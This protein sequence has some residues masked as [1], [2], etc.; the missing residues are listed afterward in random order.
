MT[1]RGGHRDPRCSGPYRAGSNETCGAGAR[2]STDS[3]PNG[4]PMRVSARLAYFMMG[5]FTL[6]AALFL[7]GFLTGGPL[8][9]KTVDLIFLGLCV[10]DA[11]FCL[12]FAVRAPGRD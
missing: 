5:F 8:F 12:W 9:S 3:R 2:V 6:G 1:R 11:L 10:V 4:P 7:V